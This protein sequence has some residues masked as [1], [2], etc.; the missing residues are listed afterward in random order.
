MKIIKNYFFREMTEIIW[1][2]M[3]VSL[4]IKG[5]GDV[6]IMTLAILGILYCFI[7]L[8]IDIF[9]F[10]RKEIFIFKKNEF[11]IIKIF[12]FHK[13]KIVIK[14]ENLNFEFIDLDK[15]IFDDITGFNYCIKIL[16]SDKEL[17]IL[18]NIYILSK[19][20]LNDEV[21]CIGDNLNEFKKVEKGIVED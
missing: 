2:L 8:L 16:T 7:I 9:F 13:K 10:E 21:I 1:I 12:L 4:F 5:F 3:F 20:N 18:R 6:F 15:S 11:I 14:K 17:K 19:N